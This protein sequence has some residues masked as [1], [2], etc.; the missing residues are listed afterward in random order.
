MNQGDVQPPAHVFKRRR[1]FGMGSLLL[2]L[3]SVGVKMHAVEGHVE[4]QGR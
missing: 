2:L 4:K 3:C 1:L